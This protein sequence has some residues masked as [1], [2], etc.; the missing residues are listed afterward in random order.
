MARSVWTGAI[1][2]GLV[3]VGV[4]AVSAVHDH[5][6]H[7]HQID[8]KTGSRIGNQKVSKETGEPV[9]RDDIELGYE[10]SKG[11]YV[12]FERDEIDELRPESTRTVGVT[13]FVDLRDIDPVF[14][15]NTYWLVPS[16]EAATHAYRLLADAME[17]T[18][19]VGI[20][21]VVMRNKQYLAAVRP[22]EGA[23]AMSTM[24]FADEVVDAGDVEGIPRKGDKP[25]AKERELA[26]QIID[27]LSTTWEPERYH[28]TFTE[29]LRSM[30]EA[31]AKG[32]ELVTQEEAEPPAKVIDLMAALERSVEEARG[33]GGRSGSKTSS[34]TSSKSGAK[35]ASK[36]SAKKSPSKKTSTPKS[37]ASRKRPARKSA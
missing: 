29:E 36:R 21:T 16:D 14:Y 32:E 11:N 17:E 24:R 4:K 31:K 19:Q 1:T 2:F 30:I 13:D 33:R 34:K 23:L 37:S 22:V 8:K 18:Q 12:T 6:V 7:F 26:T 25:S 20:G 15:E 9:D 35:S 27:A 10:V 28:D 3:S 5:D